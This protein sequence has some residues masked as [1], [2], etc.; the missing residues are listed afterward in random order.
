[1]LPVITVNPHTLS[2]FKEPNRHLDT[3]TLKTLKAALLEISPNVRHTYPVVKKTLSLYILGNFLINAFGPLPAAQAQE[4]ILPKPGDRVK[5]SATFNPPILKGIKVHADD[6]F[7]FDFILDKG[8]T[9]V[10]DAQLKAESIKLIKFFLASIT[11]PE[12]DL[13]VNLSPYEKD[14]IV[15]EGFG[16]TAM[17]MALLAQDYLLKQVAASLIYPEDEI[18]KRFWRRIYEEAANKFGTTRIP[19]NTFHKVWIVPHKA[20]VHEVASATAAY[21][22]ESSLKVLLEEDYVATHLNRPAGRPAKGN[23]LTATTQDLLREIVIPQLTREINEGKNFA[24]LRQVYN[25]LILANWYKRKVKDSILSR[26]YADQNKVAGV[27]NG[28]PQEKEKIY[29]WYVQA[30]KKGAYNYIKEETDPLSKQTLP[31]KYF[32]GGVR[33]SGIPLQLD[34][35]MSF[36][37]TL[38]WISMGTGILITAGVVGAVKMVGGTGAAQHY[39]T[40]GLDYSKL[41]DNHENL[42]KQDLRFSALQVMAKE[43]LVPLADVV[44]F[45][46]TSPPLEGFKGV[47]NMYSKSDVVGEVFRYVQAMIKL[48]MNEVRRISAVPGQ[49]GQA[50]EMS[51]DLFKLCEIIRYLRMEELELWRL[52]I[53]AEKLR[54]KDRDYESLLTIINNMTAI[55]VNGYDPKKLTVVMLNGFDDPGLGVHQDY[56]SDLREPKTQTYP[57]NI[58]IFYHNSG[59]KLEHTADQLAEILSQYPFGK[60]TAFIAYSHGGFVWRMMFLRHPELELT[61]TLYVEIGVPYAGAYG[62]LAMEEISRYFSFLNDKNKHWDEIKA[63]QDPRKAIVAQLFNPNN[64]RDLVTRVPAHL[65]FVLDGDEHSPFDE[66]GN[67]RAKSSRG[68][69]ERYQLTLGWIPHLVRMKKKPGLIHSRLAGQPQVR[70]TIVA[71][72]QNYQQYTSTGVVQGVQLAGDTADGFD[73]AMGVDPR[74]GGIDF[75]AGNANLTVNNDGGGIKFKIDPAMLQELQSEPGFQPVIIKFQP[76]IDLNLFLAG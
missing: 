32:S 38:G 16:Q 37:K 25:S 2:L 49:E 52:K 8:Q 9:S 66:H 44:L 61:K 11:T 56:L 6:P 48:R 47:K 20:V 12:N 45:K 43:A 30:F 14:R 57:Y 60:G 51:K 73:K 4:F 69:A 55:Y 53:L 35:A 31:R 41:F 46:K 34:A 24:Q 54:I 15:P 3:V 68:Y 65:A 1:M 50:Y 27:D 70:E 26:V 39:V 64:V 29:D 23:P 75:K 42:T 58:A 13:W 7:R 62:I 36:K 17:G 22:E 28:D 71:A 33:L 40:L 19:V 63:E 18:G 21:V 76:L 59:A 72:L 67:P 10:D 5:L 74:D